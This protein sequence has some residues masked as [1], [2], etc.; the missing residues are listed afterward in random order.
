MRIIIIILKKTVDKD[1][2]RTSVRELSDS[3]RELEVARI[4]D[5]ADIT[6]TSLTH[7]SEMIAVARKRKSEL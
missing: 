1:S 7:A 2:A 3:E 6:E 4:T 5:G